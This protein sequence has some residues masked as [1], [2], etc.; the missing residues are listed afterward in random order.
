MTLL[1]LAKLKRPLFT[2]F[3]FFE[4][5]KVEEITASHYRLNYHQD[6]HT[7][8]LVDVVEHIYTVY[9]NLDLLIRP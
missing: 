1:F 2:I 8:D 7:F 6:N 4:R 5:R 9:I 3:G